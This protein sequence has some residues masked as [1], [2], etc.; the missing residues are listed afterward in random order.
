MP[1]TQTDFARK[2]KVPAYLIVGFLSLG[3]VVEVLVANWPLRLHDV[4]WRLAVLDSTAGATGT[5]LLAL[6][7]LIFVAQAVSSRGA[8]WVGF[9]YSILVALAYV[10]ASCAFALDSLQV[11]GRI[12]AAQLSHFDVT[13]AWAVARFAITA[14][15]CSWLAA[16]A[17]VAAR[18]FRREARDAGDRRNALI[19]GNTSGSPPAARID[20]PGP[21]HTPTPRQGLKVGS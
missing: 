9:W 1:Q 7:L 3:S 13:V 17:L 16:C 6:L 19:V 12:P 14:L 8:V 18:A 2:L 11:R 20:R 5:E 4:N 21:P 15:V 10:V